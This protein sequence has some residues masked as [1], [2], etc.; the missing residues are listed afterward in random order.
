MPTSNS[1]STAQATSGLVTLRARLGIG[2]RLPSG[3]AYAARGCPLHCTCNLTLRFPEAWRSAPARQS[4]SQAGASARKRSCAGWS[5]WSTASASPCVRSGCRGSIP[6]ASFT[7]AL[8]RSPLLAPASIRDPLR[9]RSCTATPAAS[10]GSRESAQPRQREL[11]SCWDCALSS[12][13]GRS[14]APSSPHRR[15]RTSPSV[16]PEP[17][18]EPAPALDRPPLVA[19]CMATHNPPP[20]LLRRQLDS[21]RAQTHRNFVCVI[22][23]D[24]SSPSSYAALAAQLDGDARFVLSARRDGSA[25]T[26]T[27]NAR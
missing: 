16:E 18:P 7:R 14:R 9:T 11:R 6:S 1:P 19:I 22:S 23:D 3:L 4:S 2:V 26:T 12:G 8:T 21:I 17:E 5:W 20:D 25:S 27:S 24:C 13:T 10:G 15:G